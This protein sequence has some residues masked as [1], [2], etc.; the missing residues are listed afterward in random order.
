M[1]SA[2]IKRIWHD[3]VWSKVISAG[4]LATLAIVVT[5]FGGWGPA[6]VHAASAIIAFLSE[7]TA[8]P[9]WALALLGLC[10]AAVLFLLGVA[11]YTAVF[12]SGPTHRGYVQD[13]LLGAVWR[14]HYN[15]DGQPR[16]VAAFCATCDYQ[17]QARV[18]YP[19]STSAVVTLHCEDCQ[20]ALGGIDGTWDSLQD[21]VVRKIQQTIRTGEWQKKPQ[22][23]SQPR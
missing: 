20:K 17:L 13:V 19:Y 6:L 23:Y 8:V 21:R 15:A 14:W 9:N 7:A 2:V 3:P 4:I 5:Y 1:S 22:G 12:E 11:A 16:E 10:A 18:H